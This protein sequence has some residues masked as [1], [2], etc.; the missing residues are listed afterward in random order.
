[1]VADFETLVAS[2]KVW[3]LDAEGVVG[4]VVM[5]PHDGAYQIDNLAVDPMFQGVGYGAQLLQFAEDEAAG[6]GL[7]DMTLYTNAR[8]TENLSFYP[9]HGYREIGRRKEDGF[10][11]V[12]FG[13]SLLQKA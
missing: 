12:Y 5:Y 10:D 7:E 4:Y 2:G 3:V 6:Q 8:M 9:S 1:M 13:K 11:R